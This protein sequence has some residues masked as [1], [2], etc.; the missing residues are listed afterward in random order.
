MSLKNKMECEEQIDADEITDIEDSFAA[1]ECELFDCINTEIQDENSE[2][3]EKRAFDAEQ[4]NITENL[5]VVTGDYQESFR[6]N[7]LEIETAYDRAAIVGDEEAMKRISTIYELSVFKDELELET[8]SSDLPQFGGNYGEIK[9]IDPEGYEAHHIP[10]KSAVIGNINEM[11][12]I[13]MEKADH[14]LTDSYKARSN[15]VS[16]SFIPG[17]PQNDSYKYEVG[18]EIN[19]GNYIQ[20]VRSEIYNVREKC[21]TKYDGAIG[22]YLEVAARNIAKNGLP[23][24]RERE[25]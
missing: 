2:L 23:I 3:Y 6:F 25:R 9:E 13:S 1:E 19:N 21:G 15:R 22:Q 18:K 8:T 17:T 5:T 10:A 16:K 14:A 24:G 11:P 4:S 12:A 7:T 20:V